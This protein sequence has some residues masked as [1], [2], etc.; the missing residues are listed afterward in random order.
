MFL[1]NATQRRAMMLAL[2]NRL[3]QE[4]EALIDSSQYTYRSRL[5]RTC[6]ELTMFV[7]IPVY[8]ESSIYEDAQ[9]ILANM[10]GWHN[11]AISVYSLPKYDQPNQ[12]DARPIAGEFESRLQILSITINTEKM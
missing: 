3:T 4:I 2:V 1:P 10:N 5:G 6:H 12:V 8:I 7:T 11:C 9:V